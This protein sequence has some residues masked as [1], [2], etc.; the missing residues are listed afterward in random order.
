MTVCCTVEQGLLDAHGEVGKQLV[1]PLHLGG[2]E[3]GGARGVAA[4]GVQVPEQ[5]LDV[6]LELLGK[7]G[8]APCRP[9]G[10][11][12][13]GNLRDG[14]GQGGHRD[15][16]QEDVIPPRHTVSRRACW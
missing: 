4:D 13:H 12:D 5:R 15:D 10:D 6:P 1:G 2:R 14:D 7:L 11:D 9:A 16:A 3:R 8:D